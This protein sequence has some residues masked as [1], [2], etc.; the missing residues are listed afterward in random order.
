VRPHAG[1]A[2][3]VVVTVGLL[4]LLLR[5]LPPG[6]LS[7]HLARTSPRWLAV[8]TVL[9]V[10]VNVLRAVR[11]EVLLPGSKVGALGYVPIAFAVSLL[12]NVLPLRGGELSFVVLLKARDRTPAADSAA[13]LG[14]AR[15][16]DYLA[17]A[18]VFVP[19]AG[20]SLAH[21]PVRTDWPMRGTPTTVLLVGVMA[22]VVAAALLAMA[23]PWMGRS[24]VQA[25]VWGLARAGLAERSLS[26]RLVSFAQRMTAALEGLR[27]RSV[28][29]KTLLLSLTLWLTLF[30][31]LYAFVIGMGYQE[32]FR[33]FVVGATFAVLS[34]ALPLPTMGG[35][36]V[37]EAGWTLGFTLVGLSATDA[38]SSG[39]S[40]TILTLGLSA[41]FGLPALLVAAPRASAGAAR[42]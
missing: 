33:L 6:E 9:Y 8:A 26:R 15:L 31:W 19:L 37:A 2:A 10:A 39:L 27:T 23:L 28:Y 42:A 5:Q 24:L 7:R 16:F 11:F 22:F 25:L 1:R 3:A 18:C 21:L 36:G 20:L 29:G 32:G 34:K 12:N 35:I 17:V 4:A 38:I 13:A 41:L 14:L 30:A 40:V